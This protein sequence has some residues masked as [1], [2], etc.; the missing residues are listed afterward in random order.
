VVAG[1]RRADFAIS[2]FFQLRPRWRANA[3]GLKTISPTLRG[4]ECSPVTRR[5]SS[6]RESWR[7]RGRCRGAYTSRVVSGSGRRPGSPRS[8]TRTIGSQVTVGEAGGV[9][10]TVRPQEGDQDSRGAALC[11]AL[12]RFLEQDSPLGVGDRAVEIRPA[13]RLE[14]AG[15]R[16]QWPDLVFGQAQAK[17]RTAITLPDSGSWR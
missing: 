3:G 14:F 6:S 11:A 1:P 8:R 9:Q 16:D 13:V 15:V 12:T 5:R 10:G 7:I 4:P 17:E 2:P